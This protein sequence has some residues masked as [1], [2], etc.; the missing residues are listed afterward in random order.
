[1]QY[2]SFLAAAL[3]GLCM[4]GEVLAQGNNGGKGQGG[5]GKGNQGNNNAGNNGGNQNKNNNGNNNGGGNNGDLTLDA[6]VVQKGSQ[7]DGQQ[8]EGSA[9]GQAASKTDN[10][11]F[12][13]FCKG[14]TLT[15]G[16]QV[17]GGSCNGISK[18]YRTASLLAVKVSDACLA[19]GDIPSTDK[20]ISTIITKP[21]TGE[22]VEPNQ[23]FQLQAA[24]QNLE[25]GSFTNPDATYYA[26]P[27]QLGNGG[28]VIG[29]TH[30]TVQDMGNTLNPQLP[31]DAQKFT[32]FKGVNDAGQNGVLSATVQGG[33]KAGVYRVCTITSAS[34]HQAV[35]MPVAQ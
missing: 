14:K 31:M 5:N 20:M 16:L 19:M 30:F 21:K 13:N 11:N 6:D 29:H 8:A 7:S 9:A 18:S 27:Q 26:A 22:D 10:A 28:Q 15:N 32:F 2:Y 33:L 35:N 3:L 1:M 12:I 4:T 24:I 17:K 23:T 25:A 34:N